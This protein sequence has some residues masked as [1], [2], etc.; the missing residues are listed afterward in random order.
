MK[1]RGKYSSGNGFIGLLLLLT[2]PLAG[3]RPALGATTDFDGNGKT[4]IAFYR[5]GGPWNTVPVL[6]RNPDG[7][8]GSTNAT[9][10]DWANQPGVIAV[11][12][13]FDGNGKTAIAFYRP[14]GPWNTV[15]ILFRNP[16][17][18]WGSTNATAPDWANQ[19]G[20]I[21]YPGTSMVTARPPS[22][23]IAPAGPGTPCRSSSAIPM[24]VGARR[25]RL[26]QAGRTS[27][28]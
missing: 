3:N 24:A 5:P 4:A 19:P 2:L 21:A 18:S 23:S 17:G 14:G 1:N 27:Q 20:V 25:M 13:D 22:R 6:F 8:W 26:R 12:G 10:P 15:P 9:A 11:P 28:V 16:D 7:S